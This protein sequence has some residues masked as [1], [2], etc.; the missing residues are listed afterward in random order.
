MKKFTVAG[1]LCESGDILIKD[2]V[3]PLPKRGDI[4]A[5]TSTGAYCYTMSS[6]YNMALRP[7]VV[8]VKNKKDI[9]TNRRQKFEE[10]ILTDI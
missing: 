3:L 9:L 7:A 8:F 6:N 1:K 10:L 5:I 2:K 4:L